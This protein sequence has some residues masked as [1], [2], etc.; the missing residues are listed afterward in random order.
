MPEVTTIFSELIHS[1]EKTQTILLCW[2]C[3]AIIKRFIQFRERVKLA[4]EYLLQCVKFFKIET[5]VEFSNTATNV[6][7]NNNSDKEDFDE[8]D[9]EPLNFKKKRKKES[10]K[11]RCRL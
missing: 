2:E 6:K 9:D 1:F 5:S 3:S 8:S 11:K 7:I 4:S 10:E